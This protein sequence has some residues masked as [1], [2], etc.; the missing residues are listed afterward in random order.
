MVYNCTYYCSAN[1]EIFSVKIPSAISV[2]DAVA[3]AAVKV[4]AELVNVDITKFVL[5]CVK[6][7][8]NER[9]VYNVNRRDI[10]LIFNLSYIEPGVTPL[11]TYTENINVV[12]NA[13]DAD[14]ALADFKLND[15]KSIVPVWKMLTI[16][17]A[18]DIVTSEVLTPTIVV[19]S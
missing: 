15:S 18:T 5:Q 11:T 9:I 14:A 17:S 1:C 2:N 10:R 6:D 7:I 19:G 12:Y 13:Q 16:V 8:T 4:A 3:Q